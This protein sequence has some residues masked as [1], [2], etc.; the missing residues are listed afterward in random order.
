MA[1]VTIDGV[2]Y[3]RDDL[4]EEAVAQL[5]SIEFVDGEIARLQAPP[6]GYANLH[7]IRVRKCTSPASS[8]SELANPSL[9]ARGPDLEAWARRICGGATRPRGD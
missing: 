1:N 9:P 7:R 5:Q 4:S 6:G 8:R 2:E 3:D